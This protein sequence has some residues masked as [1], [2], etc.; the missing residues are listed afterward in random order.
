MRIYHLIVVLFA[1]IAGCAARTQPPL[2]FDSDTLL[3]HRIEGESVATVPPGQEEAL[4][5]P[6]LVTISQTGAVTAA[7]VDPTVHYAPPDASAAIA[8]A[9][10]WRFWPFSYHGRPVLA[11]G[12]VQIQ[13]R[14]PDRWRDPQASMPP[15]DYATLRIGLTRSACLGSCPDY[16]VT[17]D[18]AG[19]VTFSTRAE[20]LP[21]AAEVHRQFSRSIGVL[22]S[23][24]H[25]SRIDRPALNA[26]IDRFRQAHF[27][28]L[29]REYAAPITDS[30]TYELS[31]ESGGRRWTV[32]DYV[33]EPVGMPHVVTMLENAVD[34]AA[35]TARWI[36]GN[37]ETVAAL[38]GEGFD[39][40]SQAAGELAVT[41]VS[42][43]AA[44]NGATDQF[45]IDL[46]EAGLPLDRPVRV[47]R[48][49]DEA[50]L[51]V[52]LAIGA[53]QTHRGQLLDYLAERHWLTRIP[54]V[55]LSRLFAESG[56]GCDP[57]IA[58]ALIAAGADP[59]ARTS[60]GPDEGEPG[61]ATALIA[62]LYG[63]RCEDADKAPLVA[64]LLDV[65]VDIN[66][67]NDAGE[68]AIFGIEDPRLQ[69]QLLAAGA[70]VNVRD[71]RGNSPVFSSWTDRIVLGL[72]DAGADPRGHYDDGKTLRQQARARYMP[73]VLAWLDA[74]HIE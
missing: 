50:P 17:I 4:P 69:E 65:G 59:M 64:A 70:R 63:Y 10:H 68:T 41:A 15:I 56:G 52:A 58:R 16:A 12:V 66:A 74:H 71:R 11:E 47:M 44:R 61:G 26:L 35:G 19:E 42:K 3:R 30:P 31:F 40:R 7:R 37:H 48:G 29:R 53:A 54:R 32:T 67:T 5:V 60:R 62:A 33:G 46:I 25:H 38:R 51:G 8:A 20:S 72:L 18:G 73:S 49:G 13:Q 22:V 34:E 28:G 23:G 14:P 57:Q 55:Q 24:V 2:V 1:A 43:S 45:L 21:G 9:R 39:F 6:V 27:F 36:S